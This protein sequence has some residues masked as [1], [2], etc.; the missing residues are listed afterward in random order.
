MVPL[1]VMVAVVVGLPLAVLLSGIALRLLASVK[2]SEAEGPDAKP[3]SK[4]A[5]PP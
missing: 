4:S 5:P 3:S 2:S 1:L